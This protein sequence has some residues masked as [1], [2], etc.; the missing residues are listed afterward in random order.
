MTLKPYFGQEDYVR[1][2]EH[3]NTMPG[4]V[5][6]RLGLMT[7]EERTATQNRYVDVGLLNSGLL[8]EGIDDWTLRDAPTDAQAA[9]GEPGDLVEC[10]FDNV[11]KLPVPYA[12]K[13]LAGIYEIGLAEVIASINTTNEET[14]EGSTFR[15]A[16][17]TPGPQRVPRKGRNARS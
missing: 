12:N 9:A 2:T 1:A 15:G 10:T 14:P 17:G 4:E 8:F 13:I 6:A 7:E 16:G 11:R 5:R 3:A